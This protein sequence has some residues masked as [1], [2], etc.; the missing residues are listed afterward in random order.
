MRTK[1]SEWL[2]A[3]VDLIKELDADEG[4][5]FV[6]MHRKWCE[7]GL[8]V[9]CKKIMEI[10]SVG[11]VVCTEMNDDRCPEN[12]TEV[13]K[14][15]VMRFLKRVTGIYNSEAELYEDF[16]PKFKSGDILERK[17]GDESIMIVDIVSE[18]MVNPMEIETENDAQ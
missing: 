17:Y 9:T 10:D 16:H 4:A 1:E 11:G 12:C 13:V 15:C 3:A 7:F 8:E 18:P 2:D 5:K 14:D 6:Q